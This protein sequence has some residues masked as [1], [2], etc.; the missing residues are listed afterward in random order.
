MT[1]RLRRYIVLPSL[2]PKLHP[3]LIVICPSNPN[4]SLLSSLKN[5]NWKIFFVLPKQKLKLLL[6][7][8][9]YTSVRRSFIHQNSSLIIQ[10]LC[11]SL[12]VYQFAVI[13]CPRHYRIISTTFTI[14][15]WCLLYLGCWIWSLWSS[16]LRHRVTAWEVGTDVWVK[17]CYLPTYLPTY[18]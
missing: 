14:F 12:F 17:H 7:T 18:H 9:P 10:F 8:S 16:D 5:T 6:W 2:W 15:V 4:V 11:I 3:Y 1:Q 13:R